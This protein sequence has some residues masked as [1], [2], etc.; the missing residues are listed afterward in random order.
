V[1]FIVVYAF[2][3]VGVAALVD[4]DFRLGHVEVEAA[5]GHT[6]ASQRGGEFPETVQPRLQGGELTLG[7]RGK[8]AAC[9]TGLVFGWEWEGA[10]LLEVVGKEERV[11]L[12]IGEAFAG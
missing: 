1:A 6:F 2:E 8:G 10:D 12:F 4:V 3:P 7:K 11:G 5:V 9:G